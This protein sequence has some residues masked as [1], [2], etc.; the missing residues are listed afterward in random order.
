MFDCVLPT[1]NARNGQIFTRNGP[2]NISNSRFKYDTDPI[3]EECTC[4]TC[5]KYSK[6]YLRHLYM[7]KELLS[8]RLNT[9]HNIHYYINLMG[10][11][12]KAILN[13]EFDTFRKNFKKLATE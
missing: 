1:R 3:D 2:I 8:Y 7:S 4:Y 6:A 13:N 11:I 12:R 5:S 9:I 10:K